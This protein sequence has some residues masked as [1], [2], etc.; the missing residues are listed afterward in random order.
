MTR[1]SLRRALYAVRALLDSASLIEAV[2]LRLFL[3]VNSDV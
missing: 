2:H 3:K 1:T